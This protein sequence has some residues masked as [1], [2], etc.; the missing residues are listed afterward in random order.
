MTSDETDDSGLKAAER[1]ASGVGVRIRL[2]LFTVTPL[3]V[4]IG[5]NLVRL[6]VKDRIPYI[7][8]VFYAAPQ[9]LLVV[10]AVFLS[11]RLRRLG[12]KRSAVSLMLCA[13]L[14]FTVWR[15]AS[16]GHERSAPPETALRIAFWNVSRGD[17]G[18]EHVA[19]KINAFDADIVAVSEAVDVGQSVEFWARHCPDFSAVPLSSGMTL[20]VRGTATMI[21]H[22]RA[23]AVCRWRIASVTCRGTQMKVGIVDFTSNPLLFRKSGFEALQQVFAAYDDQPFLLAGDFN[24]P[25]E[26]VFFDQLRECGANAFEASGEGVRETWPVF[27]PLLTLDQLWGNER[28]KWHRCR[29]LWSLRSDHRPVVAEFEI[30]APADE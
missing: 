16:V 24:T 28:I 13:A 12:W 7:A 11:L 9:V 14:Q 18:Y 17:F 23:G 8:T 22:D 26:S 4:W 19:R 5:A 25:I 27:A 29:H 1:G 20:L 10:L 30:A 6:T 2:W 3:L 15:V 21:E